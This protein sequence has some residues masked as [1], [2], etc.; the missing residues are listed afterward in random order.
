MV[1]ASRS[2]VRAPLFHIYPLHRFA[3]QITT[4]MSSIAN[5]THSLDLPRSGVREGGAELADSGSV[6]WDVH[7]ACPT[8]EFTLISSDR[9]GYKMV[10]GG[11][12][13]LGGSPSPK[14]RPLG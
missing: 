3:H 2:I 11:S 1:H 7:H 9:Y 14:G 6:I 5:A 8:A 12:K 10:L 4:A 13:H